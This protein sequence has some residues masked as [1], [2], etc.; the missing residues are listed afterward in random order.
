MH[1]YCHAPALP[2][3]SVDPSHALAY[4]NARDKFNAGVLDN[5][6]SGKR[7]RDTRSVKRLLE[8]YLRTQCGWGGSYDDGRKD[9]E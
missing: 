2:Y 5:R 3:S 1:R 6:G 8:Q 7:V 4:T 9:E